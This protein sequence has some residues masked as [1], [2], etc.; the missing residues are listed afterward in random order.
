MEF[1]WRKA[2]LVLFICATFHASVIGQTGKSNGFGTLGHPH[3]ENGRDEYILNACFLVSTVLSMFGG[4][5]VCTLLLQI[6]CWSF[7]WYVPLG[8]LPQYDTIEHL[9]WTIV[10]AL[11]LGMLFLWNVRDVLMDTR[12]AMRQGCGPTNTRT[13]PN[14]P[15]G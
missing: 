13:L 6:A 14:P 12:P 3:V 10:G 1:G 9:T 7:Y 5:L 15:R 4:A 8:A 11:S 2:L